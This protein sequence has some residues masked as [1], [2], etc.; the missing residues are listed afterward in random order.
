MVERI[1]IQNDLQNTLNPE[2]FGSSLL[3][4]YQ[5][6]PVG[7]F[8]AGYN[9]QDPAFGVGMALDSVAKNTP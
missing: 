1:A 7:T 2:S 5:E 6:F 3:D 4:W 9:C 8:P